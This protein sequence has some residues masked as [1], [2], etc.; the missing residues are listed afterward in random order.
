MYEILIKCFYDSWLI[1]AF[2]I[3]IIIMSKKGIKKK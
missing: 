1:L 3:L 2:I